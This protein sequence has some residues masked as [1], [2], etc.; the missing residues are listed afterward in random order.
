MMKMITTRPSAWTTHSRGG[1]PYAV[2]GVGFF[3]GGGADAGAGGG[4][5]GFEGGKRVGGAGRGIS[6]EMVHAVKYPEQRR[7]VHQPVRPVEVGIVCE[8]HERDAEPEIRPAVPGDVQ[9]DERVGR[10]AV[11]RDCP[12]D[13]AEDENGHGGVAELA[14]D[15]RAP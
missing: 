13:E 15:L 2:Q 6:G 7:R 11:A 9:I 5:G 3:G 10:D 8:D 14:A 1:N 12:D 4:A